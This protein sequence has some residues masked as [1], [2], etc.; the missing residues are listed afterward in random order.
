[1][2]DAFVVVLVVSSCLE[3]G[4]K[5]ARLPCEFESRQGHV[6]VKLNL[7]DIV[8]DKPKGITGG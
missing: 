7:G 4:G 8:F 5:F 2:T 3:Q 6:K 1:M